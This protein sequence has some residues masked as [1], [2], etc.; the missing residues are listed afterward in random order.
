MTMTVIDGDDAAM[1]AV[2]MVRAV[3][4]ATLTVLEVTEGRDKGRV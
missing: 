3:V 4:R 2:L 1:L